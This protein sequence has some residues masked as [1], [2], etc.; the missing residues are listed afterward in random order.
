LTWLECLDNHHQMMLKEVVVVAFA[1]FQQSVNLMPI[2]MT[3]IKQEI[4]NQ[5]LWITRFLPTDCSAKD[6]DYRGEMN[7]FHSLDKLRNMNEF[8][9]EIIY[10]NISKWSPPLEF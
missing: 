1:F 2:N 8:K 9:I 4:A 7:C 10:F 6:I 3:R 5:A